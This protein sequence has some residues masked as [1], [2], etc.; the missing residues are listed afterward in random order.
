MSFESLCLSVKTKKCIKWMISSHDYW[1]FAKL[2]GKEFFRQ[3]TFLVLLLCHWFTG[4]LWPRVG[5]LLLASISS[6]LK[7]SPPPTTLSST[8]GKSPEPPPHYRALG[9]T[10]S[11]E[12][13]FLQASMSGVIRFLRLSVPHS[14]NVTVYGTWLLSSRWA[15]DNPARNTITI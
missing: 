5:L 14:G 6:S 3:G 13:G 8:E 1:S 10:Y 2:G 9:L 12:Y 7:N 15:P 11:P 4:Y